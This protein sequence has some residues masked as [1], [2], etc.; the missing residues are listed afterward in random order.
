MLDHH[1]LTFAFAEERAAVLRREAY[2]FGLLRSV[3]GAAIDA[4][5]TAPTGTA[6]HEH[7]GRRPSCCAAP[8][9]I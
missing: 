7:I 3:R 2:V 5:A 4:G 9:G 8:A 1:I 6:A